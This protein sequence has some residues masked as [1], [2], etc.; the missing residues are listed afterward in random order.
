VK[1]SYHQTIDLNQ[2]SIW[3]DVANMDLKNTD[4]PQIL[5]DLRKEADYTQDELSP[6]IGISRETISAIENGKRETIENLSVEVINKWWSVCRSKARENTRQRFMNQIMG[7]F[8]F[9]SDKL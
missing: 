5:K 8:K 7:Y 4:L 3:I 2:F 6:R 1:N 9:I